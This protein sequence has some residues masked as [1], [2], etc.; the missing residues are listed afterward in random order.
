MEGAGVLV[1]QA[2]T[3]SLSAVICVQGLSEKPV[4]FEGDPAKDT[5]MEA[6]TAVGDV[7][8]PGSKRRF[9]KRTD[10]RSSHDDGGELMMMALL[11]LLLLLLVL[12]LV[13]MLM[14][15][16]VMMMTRK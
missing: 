1:G 13:L 14:L 9:A 6:F 15:V 16:L 10:L 7:G 11:L 8:E 12:L 5:K 4:S 3:A 2:A